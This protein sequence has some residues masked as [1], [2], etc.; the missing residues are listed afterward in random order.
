MKRD[1]RSLAHNTVRLGSPAAERQRGPR[2]AVRVSFPAYSSSTALG[3]ALTPVLSLRGKTF[4]DVTS[5]I[6]LFDEA[7]G[8]E[9]LKPVTHKLP[10][11]ER[12]MLAC[13]NYACDCAKF[14]S[15]NARL[16][17]SRW[18]ANGPGPC[19]ASVIATHA[20]AS[21]QPSETE[22]RSAGG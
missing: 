18:R 21:D 5:L 11:T 20:R 22:H 8:A 6:H 12:E 17:S 10:V 14:F 19:A 9:P 3:A 2:R 1:G 13:D 16:V 15:A 4:A 7:Q